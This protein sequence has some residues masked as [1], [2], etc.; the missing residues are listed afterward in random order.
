M[1]HYIDIE[2]QIKDRNALVRAL[3]RM[4]FKNKVEIHDD[5][6]NLYGYQNDERKQ[7]ANVIIRKKF[8]SSASNDIGFEK[9]DSGFFTAHISEYDKSIGYDDKWTTKL[10]TYYG[11]E[12]A[13]QEAER[14]GLT[15]VE[16]V[17]EKNRIRLRV[18][19]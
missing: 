5:A 19:V 2:M 16:D 14:E 6:R 18:T 17:D 11:V 10:F 8:I 4:G 3:G 9:Q 7:K 1:S 12:C 13:K 15:Y